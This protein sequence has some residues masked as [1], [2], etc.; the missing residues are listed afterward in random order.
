MSLLI[1]GFS[2]GTDMTLSPSVYAA[3]CHGYSLPKRGPVHNVQK[4]HFCELFGAAMCNLGINEATLT[5]D[6]EPHRLHREHEL[7]RGIEFNLQ[8][9]DDALHR[10]HTKPSFHGD[11][12]AGSP[13]G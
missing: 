12:L 13:S 4:G 5:D 6:T 8:M 9:S 11:F 3:M 10:C 1:A 7:I 2:G